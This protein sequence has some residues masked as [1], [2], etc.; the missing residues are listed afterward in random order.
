M[1]DLHEKHEIL[2][3]CV[4]VTKPW[5]FFKFS[6]YVDRHYIYKIGKFHQVLKS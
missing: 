4:F 6:K 3:D 5:I 2:L 1:E